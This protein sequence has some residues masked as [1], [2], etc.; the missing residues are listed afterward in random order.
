MINVYTKQQI[1]LIDAKIVE[2]L[3][4][5]EVLLMENAA[6]NASTIIKKYLS[7][8][9]IFGGKIA[10]FCGTG[11]NGGDGLA[12]ARQLAYDFDVDVFIVGSLNNSSEAYSINHKIITSI[13]YI[14]TLNISHIGDIPNIQLNYACIIDALV[15]IGGGIDLRDIT[16][17]LL[18]RLNYSPCVK[19]AVDIPTGMEADTG[20][21]HTD[22]FRADMT[23]T[24]AGHKMAMLNRNAQLICG[25]IEVARLGSAGV[26]EAAVCDNFIL[27]KH[28]ISRILPKR[29][30]NTSKFDYGRI[31]IIAGS[32]TMSGAAALAANAAIKAGAGIVNLFTTR[33]HAA[34]FPEVIVEELSA[35]DQGTIHPENYDYL[36]ARCNKADAIVTGPGIGTN[37]DTL[38]MLRE[39]MLGIEHKPIIIDAD[40][41]RAIRADDRLNSYFI[42]TPHVGEFSRL[43]G[44]S[45]EEIQRNPHTAQAVAKQ[46]NCVILL[47][48]V[49]SLATNGEKIYWNTCGN[50]GMATAGAGDVLSGIIGALAARSIDTITAASL[51]ALIHALSGDIYCEK[52]NPDSL[53]ASD[54][55]DCLKYIIHE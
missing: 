41:L 42:L 11:N 55:I 13:P 16:S 8:R 20:E 39:L 52:H 38:H 37:R 30:A 10:V 19:I 7:N 23:I 27:E 47:K 12:I 49:P 26:T 14:T 24:M 36:L 18:N 9:H 25:K 46:M 29:A 48:T 5:P 43:T 4:M 21:M 2:E 33:M 51:A 28:D 15:G 17:L 32:D 44:Y 54:L 6:L 50:P 40:A 1:K 34:V 53:I 31:A 3:A 35:T 45:T 22:V